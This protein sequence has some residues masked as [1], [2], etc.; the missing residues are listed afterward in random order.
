MGKPVGDLEMGKKPLS[1]DEPMTIA[2]I[3][4]LEVGLG[5]M[6][7]EKEGRVLH[8][9]PN[10]SRDELSPEL[11]EGRAGI[12]SRCSSFDPRG[13]SLESVDMNSVQ[14]APAEESNGGGH[15]TM[16]GAH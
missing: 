13:G 11:V 10:V 5:G 2:D 4:D 12:Y 14:P 9:S 15:V 7:D 1:W 16:S 8:A 3:S 6:L